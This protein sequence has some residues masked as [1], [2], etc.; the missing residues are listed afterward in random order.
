[1]HRA[2]IA[3]AVAAALAGCHSEPV[4]PAEGSPA[5][6]ASSAPAPFD[7]ARFDAAG[8][9]V[10]DAALAYAGTCDLSTEAPTGWF[11][12]IS[13]D[14]CSLDAKALEPVLEARKKLAD[15]SPP[16][17]AMPLPALAFA[18]QARIF[19][20]FVDGVRAIRVSRGTMRTYQGLALAWNAYKPDAKIPTEPKHALDQYFVKHPSRPI[21]YIWE[22]TGCYDPTSWAYVGCEPSHPY[23]RANRYDV[24]RAHGTP[25]A[26]RTS[27]QGPF[28]AD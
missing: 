7:A 2:L 6:S 8:K 11:D 12:F 23:V 17:E 24:R 27:V 19:G 16:P 10:G 20:D 3:M 21:D 9:A 18:E 5:A 22:Q 4:A 13:Y 14:V 25:L 15:A 26:W 1:M 28:L